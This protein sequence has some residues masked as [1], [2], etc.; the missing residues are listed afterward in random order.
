MVV[1]APTAQVSRHAPAIAGGA[2]QLGLDARVVPGDALAVQQG[3]GVAQHGAD[4]DGLPCLYAPIFPD[5]RVV[6]HGPLLPQQGGGEAHRHLGEGGGPQLVG[7]AHG[8]AAP[9]RPA[10]VIGVGNGPVLNDRHL[11]PHRPMAAGGGGDGLLQLLMPLLGTAGGPAPG[12]GQRPRQGVPFPLQPRQNAGQLQPGYRQVRVKAV[13][14]HAR[15]EPPVQDPIDR[16]FRV[17]RDGLSFP[18]HGQAALRALSPP[19]GEALEHHRQLAPGHRREGGEAPL[20]HAAADPH[21][22]RPGHGVPVFLRHVWIGAGVHP[23][24]NAAEP[25]ERLDGLGPAYR[26]LAAKAPVLFRG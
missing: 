16:L 8:D 26:L 18:G 20:R 2:G 22:V 23:E 15:I 5:I 17:G 25:V 11:D 21:A 24:Q 19:C 3:G 10:I 12:K 1:I 14:R 7:A 4:G 6:I 13:V 9:Y